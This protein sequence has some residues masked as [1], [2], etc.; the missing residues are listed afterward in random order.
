MR[1]CL[2]TPRLHPQGHLIGVVVDV[3][4]VDVDDVECVPWL[5]KK[6]DAVLREIH[7]PTFGSVVVKQLELTTGISKSMASIGSVNLIDCLVEV[8]LRYRRCIVL[9]WHKYSCPHATAVHAYS[10]CPCTAIPGPLRTSSSKSLWTAPSRLGG[11][12]AR[13]RRGGVPSANNIQMRPPI[14]SSR[15]LCGVMESTS[16]PWAARAHTRCLQSL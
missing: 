16:L 9:S 8:L 12:E 3:Q 2:V 13:M 11:V 14:S 15:L 4:V 7:G 6:L 1:C 5:Q 10:V